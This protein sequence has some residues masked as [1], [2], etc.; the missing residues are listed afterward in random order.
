MKVFDSTKCILGEGPLWIQDRLYWV[1]IK[2]Y[3]LHSK[4]LDEMSSQ[5][6]KF[7]S[8][9]TALG[10]VKG[11]TDIIIAFEDGVYLFDV[12]S[13]KRSLLDN[14]TIPSTDR[15]NDGAVGPDGSFWIGTMDD[16]E[17]EKS[18][19]LL[20]YD[21]NTFDVLL[22]DIGI[23]NTV[24]WS[25][26][27]RYF[28]F[29]DSMEQ[30]IWKFEMNSNGSISNQTE[31]VSLKGTHCYPDGSA[32]DSEGYLWNA[33]WGGSRIVRYS[34]SGTVDTI[35]HVPVSQ[36]TCYA[37]GGKDYDNL[38]VTSASIGVDEELA[39]NTFILE[40][41]PKGFS[42]GSFVLNRNIRR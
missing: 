29:A 18:G 27:H 12:V 25:P 35:V 21:G 17:K 11:K 19:C 39:G 23:S 24:V 1:D 10:K 30:V 13:G 4:R 26:D 9:P 7:S 38:F 2:D 6:W 32:V 42:E 37:F 20:R 41:I 28:Y 15:S 22:K 36:P 8:R 33:Q 40:G 16:R 31:F 5:K 14:L 34:P 3:T